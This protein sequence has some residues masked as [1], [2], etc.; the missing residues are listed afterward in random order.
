MKLLFITNVY[1]T[2]WEPTRGV[3]NRGL[4]DALR[5][6]GHEV[7]CVVPVSWVDRLR[8][9]LRGNRPA[10]P[11]DDVWF[12]VWFYPPKVSRSHF[13]QYMHLS[14]RGT[15]REATR[16]WRPDAVL[17]YWVHPDAAVGLRFARELGIPTAAFSGGSDLLIITK[18]PARQ[19]VVSAVLKNVEA[20][21]TDGQ[22]LRDAAV[23][24]GAS[25]ERVHPFYRGVDGEY[26]HPG[27]R[28][29]AR[30]QLGIPA[31]ARMLLTVGNMVHVKGFDILLQ[32][33]VL[34]G[35]A[36]PWQVYMIG[37]G[38]LRSSLMEQVRDLGLSSRVK[39][40]GRIPHNDLADWFRA[41]NRM[42]LPS[43][44]EGVPNVLL[45]TMA[46]GVPFIAT[47]VGGIPEICP[48]PSWLIPPENQRALAD[49]LLNAYSK[50]DPEVPPMKFGWDATTTIVT[51]VLTR[52]RNGNA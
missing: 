26:F 28:A 32:A 50:P 7:R 37:D 45:E 52:L 34:A 21:F 25:P 15:L 42:V 19:K 16:D 14:I 44:S 43:R 40:I 35:D 29:A 33:L 6:V 5:R 51:D 4:V 3:F 20:V 9:S 23:R 18:D 11:D 31:D 27:D 12:P 47:S 39:F 10:A 1:P 2:P 17:G 13:D 24:L 48:D 8:A 46:C 36:A 30:A 49:A 38:P 22:H 41:S